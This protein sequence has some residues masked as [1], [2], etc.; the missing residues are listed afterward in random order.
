MMVRGFQ[1]APEFPVQKSHVA[2]QRVILSHGMAMICYLKEFV[3]MKRTPPLA[4]Q[5]GKDFKVLMEN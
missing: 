2:E 4:P 5:E 1:E 3:G